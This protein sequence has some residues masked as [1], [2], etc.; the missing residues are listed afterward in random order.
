MAGTRLFEL[1]SVF[2]KLT[3]PRGPCDIRDPRDPRGPCD[4]RDPC[5]VRFPFHAL[6][7][8]V[9]LGL[10]AQ[11]CEMAVLVRWAKAHSLG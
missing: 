8:I 9:F 2:Q 3:D 7:S 4:L 1:P 10:L 11:I 6:C 5:G